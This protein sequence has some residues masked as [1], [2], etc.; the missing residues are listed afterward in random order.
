MPPAREV[1]LERRRT[2]PDNVTRPVLVLAALRLT[3]PV[4]ATV[5]R[6]EPEKA[7]VKVRV[8]ATPV[9]ASVVLMV[10]PVAASV[11]ESQPAPS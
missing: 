8:R 5:R 2:P 10:R 9:A 6:P 3:T 11:S 7:P 4:P 1:A